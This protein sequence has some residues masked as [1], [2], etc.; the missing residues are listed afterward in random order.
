MTSSD[1][2]DFLYGKDG[3]KNLSDAANHVQFTPVDIKNIKTE[4]RNVLVQKLKDSHHLDGA[5]EKGNPP[6][7][8]FRLKSKKL[9]KQ[10]NPEDL[11]VYVWG[12]A[13]TLGCCLR[14]QVLLPGTGSSAERTF[15]YIHRNNPVFS[16]LQAGQFLACFAFANKI[17]AAFSVNYKAHPFSEK[18]YGGHWNAVNGYSP[19]LNDPDGFFW[20]ILKGKGN[21]KNIDPWYTSRFTLQDRLSISWAELYSHRIEEVGKFI[22]TNRK[23]FSEL[24]VSELNLCQHI[25]DYLEHLKSNDWKISSG[26][27]FISKNLLE[28][29]NADFLIDLSKLQNLN[30]SDNGSSIPRDIFCL[31]LRSSQMTQCGTLRRWIDGYNLE[32]GTTQITPEQ[33]TEDG[34]IDYYWIVD[35]TF[36]PLIN[37][38]LF[39]TGKDISINP[40][41]MDGGFEGHSLGCSLEEADNYSKELLNEACLNKK[42]TIPY[43][44][45]VALDFGP[46][47]SIECYETSIEIVFIFRN[48][49]GKYYFC[50][51]NPEMGSFKIDLSFDKKNKKLEKTVQGEIKILLSAIIRDFHVVEEREKNIFMQVS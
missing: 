24:D 43:G 6:V 39:I 1:E 23:N 4:E 33:I 42:W 38:G 8:L 3:Q 46:F 15:V 2:H 50:S 14:F 17:V 48:K 44:A 37:F 11:R 51:V 47:S 32:I 45:I 9:L 34:D 22:Q 28:I 7:L 25:T 20:E 18:Y 41:E 13:G 10:L 29:I 16:Q 31:Y 5:S 26:Y 49:I 27:E 40:L 19:V 21:I 35:D 30:N 36:D 12:W